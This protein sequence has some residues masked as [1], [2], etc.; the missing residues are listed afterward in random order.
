M[1]KS[2]GVTL[3]S[4]VTTV[5][6]LIILAAV[7]AV[8]SMDAYNQMRFETFK[9]KLEEVQKKVNEISSDY[10]VYLKKNSGDTYANYFASKFNGS[11]PQYF[12]QVYTN[13]KFANVLA[14]NSTLANNASSSTTLFYFK[15]SDVETFLGLKGIDDIIVDFSTRTVYSVKGCKD[16]ND[17]S[18]IYYTPSDYDESTVV[19]STTSD[20]NVKSSL[21]DATL[22]ATSTKKTSGTTTMYQ[23]KLVVSN[24]GSGIKYPI[25]AV[26]YSTDNTNWV[27]VSNPTINDDTVSFILYTSKKYYF[28]VV[29]SKDSSSK[30]AELTVQ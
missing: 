21:I 25:N 23:I 1:R 16:P 13:S 29:D 22:T 28:K 8:T 6:V 11:W 19:G 10:G 12:S 27:K 2:K 17:S 24:R 7:T 30:I 4:V 14:S 15:E 3:I 18:I 26:Y 5:L 20:S 9:E